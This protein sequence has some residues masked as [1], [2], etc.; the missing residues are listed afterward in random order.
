MNDILIKEKVVRKDTYIFKMP[1]SLVLLDSITTKDS[2]VIIFTDG[3]LTDVDIRLKESPNKRVIWH[4]NN[5]VN[6]MINELEGEY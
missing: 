5:A 3:V 6:S 2:V 1:R 4:I